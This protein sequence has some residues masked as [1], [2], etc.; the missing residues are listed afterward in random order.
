MQIHYCCFS[1]LATDSRNSYG[2]QLCFSSTCSFVRKSRLHTRAS[3]EKRSLPCF[4][5]SRCQVL[6]LMPWTRIGSWIKIDWL[7]FLLV[8]LRLGTIMSGIYRTNSSTTYINS[9]HEL[10][11][12][13]TSGATSSDCSWKFMESW[14]GTTCF[15]AAIIC[16]LSVSGF[17]TCKEDDTRQTWYHLCSTTSLLVLIEDIH[18]PPP[19]NSLLI[20]LGWNVETVTSTLGSF[21]IFALGGST[22]IQVSCRGSTILKN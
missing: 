21:H 5:H 12:N 14:V 4:V 13:V 17:W 15:V 6:F 19:W 8:V 11:R 7:I 2:E 18:Y 16:L 20:L 22:Y 9:T 10:K 1:C 3:Y